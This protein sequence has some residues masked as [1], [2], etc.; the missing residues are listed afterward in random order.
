MEGK[1]GRGVEM[2]ALLEAASSTKRCFSADPIVFHALDAS[3]NNDCAAPAPSNL[4]EPPPAM[5]SI[6]TDAGRP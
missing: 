2:L 6:P 3:L 4:T 5:Q 1:V